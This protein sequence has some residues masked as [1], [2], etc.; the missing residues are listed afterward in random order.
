MKKWLNI[1]IGELCCSIETEKFAFFRDLKSNYSA[2]ISHQRPKLTIN[3]KMGDNRAVKAYYPEVKNLESRDILAPSSATCR[4]AGIVKKLEG[5]NERKRETQEEKN[6]KPK[7]VSEKVYEIN[8]L[9][10]GKCQSGP[11]RQF[12]CIRMPKSS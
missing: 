2:F 5:R 12:A 8:V 1:E 10:C 7:V 11:F 4:V 9:K 3:V 6:E